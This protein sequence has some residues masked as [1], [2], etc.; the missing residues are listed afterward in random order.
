MM[1]SNIPSVIRLLETLIAMR[2][3]DL[4]DINI[5]RLSK[6]SQISRRSTSRALSE[7]E[8]TEVISTRWQRSGRRGGKYSVS[9]DRD[10]AEALAEHIANLPSKP[11]K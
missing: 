4:S 3:E 11:V 1:V 5:E 7:L 10:R 8:R 9:V 2:D 6:R